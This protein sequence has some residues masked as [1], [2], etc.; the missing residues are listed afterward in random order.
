MVTE[1]TRQPLFCDVAN[2][3]QVIVYKNKVALRE[4]ADIRLY[5]DRVTIDEGKDD[6]VVFPFDEVT[7]VSVLG[8]NKLNIY[9]D[10]K[11]Y[12]FKGSKRF[13]ALKYVNMYYHYKNINKG[14][15]N[16]EFLGL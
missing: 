13:N 5:G 4:N 15:I 2:L 8:R 6:C 10:D 12:Q 14:E 3:S 7:A 11:V 1:H 16:G 9:H